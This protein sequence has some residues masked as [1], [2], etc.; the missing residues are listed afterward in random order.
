M[1]GCTVG[2][3]VETEQIYGQSFG[4]PPG[5]VCR[6]RGITRPGLDLER[7]PV[8]PVHYLAEGA[9]G[10]WVRGRGAVKLNP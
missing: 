7:F 1:R 2:E 4:V 5:F 6:L 8:E 3:G 10:A 9:V